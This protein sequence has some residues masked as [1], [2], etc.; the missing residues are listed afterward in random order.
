MS[1]E[2]V[3]LEK[4]YDEIYELSGTATNF[5]KEILAEMNHGVGF[6]TEKHRKDFIKYFDEK[7]NKLTNQYNKLKENLN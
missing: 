5:S 2:E 7:F 1:K 6:E 3:R 4:L